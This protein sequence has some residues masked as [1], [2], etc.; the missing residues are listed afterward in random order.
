MRLSA[1]RLPYCYAVPFKIRDSHASHPR[2]H[3]FQRFTVIRCVNYAGITDTYILTFW[4]K[5]A[6]KLIQFQFHSST[7]LIT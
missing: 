2:I 7:V 5:C 3:C 1:H 4:S 6:M